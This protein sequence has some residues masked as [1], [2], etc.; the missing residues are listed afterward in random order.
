MNRKLKNVLLVVVFF[1]YFGINNALAGDMSL[2]LNNEPIK[3]DM[4]NENGRVLV[5][6]R[7]ICDDMGYN[8]SWDEDTRKASIKKDFTNAIFTVGEKDIIVNNKKIGID[9]APRIVGDRT[10]VPIRVFA[11]A[12][13]DDIEYIE[14][15]NKINIKTNT[16]G[17][18]NTVLFLE[19][20]EEKDLGNRKSNFSISVPQ[21]LNYNNEVSLDKIN[22]YYKKEGC[23]MIKGFRNIDTNVGDNILDEYSGV[24]YYL[25]HNNGNIISFLRIDYIKVCGVAKPDQV[26]SGDVF[27][28]KTGEKLKIQDILKGTDEEIEEFLISELDKIDGWKRKCYY[29]INK[30]EIKDCVKEDKYYFYID[31]G[32]LILGAFFGE[33]GINISKNKELFNERFL[34]VMFGKDTDEEYRVIEEAHKYFNKDVKIIDKTTLGNDE[35]YVFYGKGE[36]VAIDR[37]G[38][39]IYLIQESDNVYKVLEEKRVNNEIGNLTSL[40]LVINKMNLKDYSYELGGILR[41]DEEEYTIVTMRDLEE[42][43][44]SSVAVNKKTGE[45]LAYYFE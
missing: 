8:V 6:L 32:K 31:N 17:N 12:F 43:I 25:C 7:K 36:L 10:Y 20:K 15:E 18:K 2:V 40:M 21:I 4:F 37:S 1:L 26:K 34:E 22:S 9:V 16:N 33:T 23:N 3:L 13:N 24:N 29:D 44:E 28:I 5:P 41:E 45:I 14:A 27:N 30:E 39:K 19:K 11:E 42:K 35:C 38:E